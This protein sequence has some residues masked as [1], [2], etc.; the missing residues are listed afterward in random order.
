MRTRRI[1]GLTLAAALALAFAWF[2]SGTTRRL[3]SEKAAHQRTLAELEA[4][5]TETASLREQLPSTDELERRKR[6]Q[7]EL[8]RL[9]D[10]VGRLRKGVETRPGPAPT[11]PT[12]P[13]TAQED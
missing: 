4:L 3:H 10:E 7:S 12:P 8:L 13:A 9:R 6:E 2:F 11:A 5:R 1:A